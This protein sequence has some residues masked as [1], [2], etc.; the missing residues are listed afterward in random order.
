MIWIT[1]QTST[2]T[3]PRNALAGMLLGFL[4]ICDSSSFLHEFGLSAWKLKQLTIMNAHDSSTESSCETGSMSR[5]AFLTTL[6]LLP[7]AAPAMAAVNVTESPPPNTAFQESVSG[8]VAGGALT[9]TKT[10]VKYPL[11]SATVR[12]QMPNSDYSLK[13]LVRLFDGGYRGVTVPLVANIPAGAVFFAVKDASKAVMAGWDAP[14]WVKTFVAVAAAQGPYWL[15]RN[16]SEVVKTRQQ[17]GI[18]GYGEGVSAVDAY[19]YTREEAIRNSNGTS[20][21]LEDFYLGYWE[22]IIYA[23]PADVIKFLC[24][25]VLSKGRKD[26]NPAEGALAGAAST[27]IAQFFTTPLDVVRNR[28]MARTDNSQSKQETQSP[29]SYLETLVQ[30]GKQEGLPGL[31]AG[32]SPRVGKALLSGAIQFATYE[33]TK[34]QIAKQF[35]IQ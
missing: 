12:L 23:Y 11:D 27:A 31:F 2:M 3:L 35:L 4:L 14:R 29:P 33:E 7:M 10:L 25:D 9:C 24:Y 28:I 5:S 19:R 21:G 17:A 1:S 32:A 6:M 8:A 26:L 22:N 13:N 30:L 20:N 15:V 18:E 16:P 34:Q